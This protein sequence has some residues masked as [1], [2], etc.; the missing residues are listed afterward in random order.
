MGD[1]DATP[2][3][4][5]ADTMCCELTATDIV[6]GTPAERVL[7]AGDSIGSITSSTVFCF[8]LGENFAITISTTTARV[9]GAGTST[10][11]AAGN[12]F[13]S[14]GDLTEIAVAGSAGHTDSRMLTATADADDFITAT[15]SACTCTGRLPATL[16]AVG[17]SLLAILASLWKCLLLLHQLFFATQKAYLMLKFSIFFEF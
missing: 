12:D 15:V 3:A 4:D 17:F 14:V 2:D 1:C 6:I 10:V 9:L 7:A 8:K 13:C 11:W 16:F 5:G